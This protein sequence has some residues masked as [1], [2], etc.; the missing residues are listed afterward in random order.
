VF[1]A[2]KHPTPAKGDPMFVLQ[3]P[4]FVLQRILSQAS[5]VCIACTLAQSIGCAGRATDN[6]DPTANPTIGAADED[7]TDLEQ[8]EQNLQDTSDMEALRAAI[9]GLTTRGGEGDPTPYTARYVALP[10][11]GLQRPEIL[12]ETVGPKLRRLTPRLPNG[13]RYGYQSYEADLSRFWAAETSAPASPVDDS[14]EAADRRTRM[15]KLKN[16]CSARFVEVVRLVVG[17]RS[18]ASDSSSIENGLVAPMIVGRLR[19]GR[20]VALS[21]YDVWT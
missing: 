19:S 3:D 4:M 15:L 20:Y 14:P 10:A 9:Q 16:V 11:S 21:G 13:P 17:V 12:A 5:L 1:G 2:K 7:L 6:G 18:V 8:A